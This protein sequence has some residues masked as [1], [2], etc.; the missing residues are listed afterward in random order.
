MMEEI[1]EVPAG[2]VGIANRCNGH[3][4]RR[5]AVSSWGGQACVWKRRVARCGH[6]VATPGVKDPGRFLLDADWFAGYR[7]TGGAATALLQM[8]A[9]RGAK[10]IDGGGRHP[11]WKLGGFVNRGWVLQGG[12]RKTRGTLELGRRGIAL[13][14]L[15]P[16]RA[17]REKK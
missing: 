9:H 3:R 14:E 13:V 7:G 15:L 10:P 17:N 5:R 2:Q 11:R 4:N 6:A 8:A 1:N 16:P 12:T